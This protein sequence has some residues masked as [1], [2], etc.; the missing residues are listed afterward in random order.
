[1]YF[2]KL[3]KCLVTKQFH[4]VFEFILNC[5]KI[6]TKLTNLSNN[7]ELRSIVMNKGWIH[8]EIREF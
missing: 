8:G 6:N 7:H 3:F 4:V 1:M 2:F 5:V